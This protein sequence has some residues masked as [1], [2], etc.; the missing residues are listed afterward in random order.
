M[1]LIRKVLPLFF[2]FSASLLAGDYKNLSCW[3]EYGE[4]Y[5]I[6]PVLLY[7]IAYIESGLDSKAINKRSDKDKDIGLMQINSW[8]FDRLS[9]LNI[10]EKDLYDPCTNIKVGAWILAHSISFFG[11]KW[12][13]VGGY[14]AGTK[15]SKKTEAIRKK[16]ALKVFSAYVN[17][18]NDGLFSNSRK[19]PA[20]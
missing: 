9:K 6:D 5:K 19:N 10:L 13:A 17:F 2:W 1:I 8:W 18:H 11:N 12:R 14:N 7:S 16:Y 3:V 20:K 4:Y 15:N